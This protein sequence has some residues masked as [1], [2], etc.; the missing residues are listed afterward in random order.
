MNKSLFVSLILMAILVSTYYVPDISDFV[1]HNYRIVCLIICGIILTSIV[2][3]VLKIHSE[4][5]NERTETAQRVFDKRD[6]GK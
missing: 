1:D 4:K 6:E 3:L 5:K 2:A